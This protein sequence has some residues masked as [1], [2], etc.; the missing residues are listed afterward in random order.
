[1]PR[2]PAA[3]PQAAFGTRNPAARATARSVP[4]PSV[5]VPAGIAQLKQRFSSIQGIDP[6]LARQLDSLQEF[7]GA[8]QSLLKRV[9]FLDGNLIPGV[10]FK[11][12]GLTTT[13]SHNLGRLW[14]GCFPVNVFGNG[15]A[16]FAEPQGPN[17]TIGGLDSRTIVIANS[18][19]TAGTL[20]LW[21][22]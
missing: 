8:S 18:L 1:M 20:D 9:P 21:V 14:R 12:V 4:L 17:G 10:A 13:V 11:A 19:N 7:I 3:I 6:N 2:V 5:K 15:V 16:L 22:Y